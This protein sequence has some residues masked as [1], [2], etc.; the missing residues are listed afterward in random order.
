MA[1]R[2]RRVLQRRASR[3]VARR[4]MGFDCHYSL[5][6]GIVGVWVVMW[7]LLV[8]AEPR[9]FGSHLIYESFAESVPFY[10]IMALPITLL[11]IAR[12]I[13]LSFGSIMALSVVTFLAVFN[14][15]GS[16]LLAFVACLG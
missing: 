15:T 9:T 16:P 6:I 14:A 10:G 11:V 12:E 1:K 7:I 4:L 8:I 5:Q 2:L 13:D 3:T